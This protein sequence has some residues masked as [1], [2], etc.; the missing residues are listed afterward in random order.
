MNDLTK[1]IQLVNKAYA[2]LN[3]TTG[4]EK[5]QAPVVDKASG[6]QVDDQ[7]TIDKLVSQSMNRRRELIKKNTEEVERGTKVQEEAVKT[8]ADNLKTVDELVR[9]S[10]DH[11]R[12][13]QKKNT[14][15]VQRVEKEAA[16]NTIRRNQTITQIAVDGINNLIGV[17]QGYNENKLIALDQQY[18]K[19]KENIEKSALSEE[20][21]QIK[22][23]ELDDATAKKKRALLRRQAILEKVSGIFSIG[24]ST[25]MAAMKA[26]AD[27]GP[28]AGTVAAVLMAIIGAAQI[29]IVAAKPIPA[30]ARGA[31]LPGT[32]D[33]SIIRAGEN[34]RAEIILPMES[35][36]DAVASRIIRR[37]SAAAGGVGDRASSAIS[38][39]VGGGKQV[40]QNF[41]LQVG[42]RYVDESGL[43][44]LW[45]DMLPIA[46][47]ESTRVLQGA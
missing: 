14:E 7:D 12:E 1:Q 37:V 38:G 47:A 11:R 28:I 46:Q 39:A 3:K 26:Y 4:T 9:K 43:K 29:A 2:D 36:V 16:E 25:A 31:Y 20:E 24:I 8:E 42:N 32:E 18:E 23:Q 13:I 33:G 30:A 41:Y 40:V 21:K 19:E 6:K 44:R 34:R 15:E 17:F 10:M 22:F 45:R 27:L 35:G 5:G